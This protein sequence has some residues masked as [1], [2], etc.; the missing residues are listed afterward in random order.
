MALVKNCAVVAREP[1]LRNIGSRATTAQFFTNAID[2]RTR[3]LD[4]TGNYTIE[5]LGGTVGLNAVFN[6]T[7]TTIPNEDNI[8]LPPEL[9]GTGVTLVNKYDEGGLL[10]ITKAPG[11]A[12]DGHGYLLTRI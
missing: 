10:A 3:G 9:Q 4:L 11:M 12:G 5:T 8:P 6:F 2:T 7:R 1:I